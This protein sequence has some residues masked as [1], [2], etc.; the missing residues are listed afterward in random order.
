MAYTIEQRIKEGEY[1]KIINYRDYDTEILYDDNI[2]EYFYDIDGMEAYYNLKNLEIPKYAY[3]CEFAPVKVD[4]DWILESACDDH[5]EGTIDRLKGVGDLAI[6]IEEF[7][8][9]NKE[10]GSYYEDLRTIIELF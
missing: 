1:D 10:I 8:N 5:A 2:G 4:I 6:A 9:A 7:N 3:G